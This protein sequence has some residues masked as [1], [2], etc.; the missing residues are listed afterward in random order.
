MY[1]DAPTPLTFYN[2]SNIIMTFVKDFFL[3]FS[4]DVVADR[5][6]CILIIFIPL[7]LLTKVKKNNILDKKYA[8]R[9]LY[10]DRLT[11]RNFTWELKM[12][13]Y[14]KKLKQDMVTCTIKRWSRSARSKVCVSVSEG[15]MSVKMTKSSVF[16]TLTEQ[17]PNEIWEM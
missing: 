6:K 9:R 3:H 8:S 7:L 2:I 16:G 1:D 17:K 13:L 10:M 4:K 5:Y 14:L 11:N 12:S 15:E